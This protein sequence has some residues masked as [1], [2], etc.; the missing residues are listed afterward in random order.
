MARAVDAPLEPPIAFDAERGAARAA[1]AL[2]HPAPRP[3]VATAE[4]AIRARRHELDGARSSERWPSFML[5][6]QY[7][8][9]PM[10]DEPHNYGVTVSVSLPWLNPRYGEEA[11]AAEARV[12]AE[13]SALS[14]SRNAVRYE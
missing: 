1:R 9:M 8:F 2:Q 13:Q 10:A 7:M 3:E 12:A 14:S 6:I 5:G 4:S 11:R